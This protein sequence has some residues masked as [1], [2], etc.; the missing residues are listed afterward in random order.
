MKL[1]L[2]LWAITGAFAYV[3]SEKVGNP[4]NIMEKNTQ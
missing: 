4:R 1:S 2:M 3:P